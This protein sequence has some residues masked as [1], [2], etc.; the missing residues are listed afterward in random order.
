MGS[1]DRREQH[2]TYVQNNATAGP[3]DPAQ[4]SYM[5]F[6]PL[7]YVTTPSVK[8][9]HLLALN[10][11]IRPS[12][13]LHACLFLILLLSLLVSA[14]ANDMIGAF[15]EKVKTSICMLKPPECRHS[16]LCHHTFLSLCKTLHPRQP[17]LS[18]LKHCIKSL[19]RCYAEQFNSP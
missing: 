7:Y 19:S 16:L 12:L 3:D 5:H 18:G 11:N 9:Q 17:H 14:S 4:N 2:L 6:I 1:G 10:P 15:L 8:S 13:R